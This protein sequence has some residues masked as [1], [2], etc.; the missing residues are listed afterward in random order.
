MDIGNSDCGE[1]SFG[2]RIEDG[3]LVFQREP[4]NS[5][6]ASDLY[7]TGALFQTGL[8]ICIQ[9]GTKLSKALEFAILGVDQLQGSGYL[10]HGLI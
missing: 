5:D 4:E 8:G 10:F 2:N 9:I 1:D 3:Y 6:S 7:D